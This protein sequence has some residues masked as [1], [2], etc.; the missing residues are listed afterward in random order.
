MLGQVTLPA[1]GETSGQAACESKSTWSTGWSKSSRTPD[2]VNWWPN[3]RTSSMLPVKPAL[4]LWIDWPTYE[5]ATG[6][7]R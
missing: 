6:S 1:N 7:V 2:I 5:L 3:N 4:L